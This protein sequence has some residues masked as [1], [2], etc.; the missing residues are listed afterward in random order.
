MFQ[1]L[2]VFHRVKKSL[3]QLNNAMTKV[4]LKILN[5]SKDIA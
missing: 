2:K 5:K 1:I 3:I 4:K